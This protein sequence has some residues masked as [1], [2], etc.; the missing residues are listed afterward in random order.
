MPQV[1][2]RPTLS[3]DKEFCT[4]E[5]DP[6]GVRGDT[7]P[8]GGEPKA[9]NVPAR[10]RG[11]DLRADRLRTGVL[12]SRSFCM[13]PAS[14]LE[15]T[16]DGEAG[17]PGGDCMKDEPRR[18]RGTPPSPED[19]GGEAASR[20]FRK[21]EP[22][23]RRGAMGASPPDGFTYDAPRRRRS[24]WEAGGDV[25]EEAVGRPGSPPGGVDMGRLWKVEPLRKRGIGLTSSLACA[26]GSPAATAWSRGCAGTGGL[27]VACASCI[28][29]G[30]SAPMRTENEGTRPLSTRFFFGEGA[31]RG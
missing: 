30:N 15:T 4:S 27:L 19:G 12:Y 6:P 1:L 8:L 24:T 28:V 13:K 14:R 5:D 10:G 20:A 29:S 11:I 22:R 9:A 21:D 18:R 3:A 16:R 23:R 2:A 25:Y 7:T 17:V 31:E 26:V